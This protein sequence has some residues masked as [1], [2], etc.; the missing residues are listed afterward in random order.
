MKVLIVLFLLTSCLFS[1]TPVKMD[2]VDAEPM[3]KR[4]NAPLRDRVLIDSVGNIRAILGGQGKS[5]VVSQNAEAVAV[6]YGAPSGDPQNSMQLKIAYS[7]DSGMTWTKYGP[8][9][10]ACRRLY[11]SVDGVPDFHTHPGHLYFIWQENT[12]GY[13]DGSIKM[14]IEQ[15]VPS[16]PFFSVP[17]VLPQSQ[18]PAMYPW[19]P[20]I[21]IDPDNSLNLIATAYS[22]LANGNEWAY[23]WISHDGG[24]TWSDTIP[25]VNIN[26][27]GSVGNL[28]R[29]TGGYV[30]YTYHDYYNFSGVDST[31]YPYYIESTDG[32][33]TWSAETPVPG[34]PVNSG[35]I[36]WWHEMDCLVIENQPW[37]VHTDLGDPG[38]GPFI[39]RGYGSPGNW[40]WTIW[41]AQ[42][43]GKD[44]GSWGYYI[45][46]RYPSLSYD[47]VIGLILASWKAYIYIGNGSVYDGAHIQGVYTRDGGASWRITGPL[48]SP[49][50][51][52]IGW[53]AW[54]ATEVAHRCVG[55][56]GGPWTVSVGSYAVW[57]D[58]VAL[59]LYF[60][61]GW[62]LLTAV[63]EFTD[64]TLRA[65]MLSVRPTIVSNFSKAYLTLKDNADV[66]VKLYDVAGR[67][68]ERLFIGHLDEGTYKIDINAENLAGGI[69]LIVL[70]TESGQQVEKIVVAR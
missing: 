8:F 20:D 70:E 66:S 67:S 17:T 1:H 40:I 11:N 12:Q 23:C 2:D 65:T 48:S 5:I 9:S 42:V 53:F 36:F 15:N 28:S 22:Y 30:V 16:D 31:P 61:R 50:S 21:A 41:D 64:S 34:V 3:L 27:D 60:E 47:P 10:E 54:N 13:N 49:N 56:A 6:I 52:A 24:D 51:G 25:M 69:Y 44:S 46:Y 33:Y 45:P 35:S 29:G 14:M 38:G 4:P 37:F 55:T 43:I 68:V 59:V 18:P 32:G 63:E 39:M 19:E 26:Q 7:E 57:I 58:E 62:P